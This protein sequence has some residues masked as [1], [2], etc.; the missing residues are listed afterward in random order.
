[1]S[2]SINSWPERRRHPRGE[3]QISLQCIRLDPD[4][5]D[6]LET[7]S[8]LDISRGGMGAICDRPFYPGQRA[9]ICMPLSPE[10]GQR[11]IY[12]T[13]V[14]CRQMGKAY[15]VGFE[16]DRVSLGAW[17]GVSGAEAAAA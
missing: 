7:L 11:N 15:R 6:V 17:C 16:F 14:R 3:M 9:L 1:M 2:E 4:G 5:G 13:I 12:A 10:G 8:M